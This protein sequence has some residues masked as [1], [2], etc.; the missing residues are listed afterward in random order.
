[1]PPHRKTI[2]VTGT[3][4]F[5][6]SHLA[7]HLLSRGDRVV[8]LDDLQADPD[9]H[10][11]NL[12]AVEAAA[13]GARG[14]W[15]FVRGD[16]CDAA[17]LERLFGE[18]AFDAVAHLAAVP[19]GAASIEAPGRCWEVNLGGTL[20]LL[21]AARSHAVTRFVFASSSQVYGNAV[22]APLEENAPCGEPPTPFAAAKRAAE[23]LGFSY[24]HLYGLNFT[25]L[26]LFSVYGP[27]NR[28]ESLPSRVAEGLA[29]GKKI[30]LYRRGQMQ[31]DW[32]FIGDLLPAIAAAADRALGYEIINLGRGEPVLA[33]DFVA[34][35]ERFFGKRADL[36]PALPPD[37]DLPCVYA[38]IEKARGLLGFAPRTPLETGVKAFWEWVSGKTALSPLQN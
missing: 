33:A 28:P 18:N 36:L 10:R 30:R 21:E 17:L 38:R 25:A 37:L 1:M 23:L 35:L 4:G 7:A 6:G 12:Q 26:R 27:R 9:R 8:G 3:A 20:K 32:I 5:I 29:S 34:L 19:G 13:C 15:E 24:H 2:L 14:H 11:E 31:R 16:V 22:Q